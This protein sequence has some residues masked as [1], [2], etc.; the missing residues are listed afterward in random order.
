MNMQWYLTEFGDNVWTPTDYTDRYWSKDSW[1]ISWTEEGGE[2]DDDFECSSDRV[3][4]IYM[5]NAYM[6]CTLD[7]GCGGRYQAVFDLT[8]EVMDA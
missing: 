7:D 3:R 5:T 1:G 8:K 4:D 6:L 2:Y